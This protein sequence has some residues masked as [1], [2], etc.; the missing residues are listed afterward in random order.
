M[1]QLNG[2]VLTFTGTIMVFFSLQPPLACTGAPSDL[3][4]LDVRAG[5][6]R[7]VT[8]SISHNKKKDKNI[9]GRIICF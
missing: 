2:V 3:R 6:D 1:A 5:R 4:P 8:L 7:D 9:L